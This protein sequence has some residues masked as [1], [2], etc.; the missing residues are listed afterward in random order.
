LCPDPPERSRPFNY[1]HELAWHDGNGHSHVRASLF[2]PSLTVPVVKGRMTLG[3]WQQI[4]FI[5]FDRPARD[6]EITVQ[7]MGD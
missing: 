5:D 2:G 3:T 6:R 4:I 7:I 1:H